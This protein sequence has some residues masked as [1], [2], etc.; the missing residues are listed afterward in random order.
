MPHKHKGLI[1]V[2]H[3]HAKVVAWELAQVIRDIWECLKVGI[4][5]TCCRSIE[6]VQELLFGCWE[7]SWSNFISSLAFSAFLWCN[8]K[9]FCDVL[10]LRYHF[11]PDYATSHIDHMYLFWVF[12]ISALENSFLIYQYK[13]GTVCNQRVKVKFFE[14]LKELTVV[15][16]LA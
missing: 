9:V 5:N 6:M 14:S 13:T 2:T 12:Q 10:C 15:Q 7:Y 8:S 3:V 4:E 11:L 16:I 1:V